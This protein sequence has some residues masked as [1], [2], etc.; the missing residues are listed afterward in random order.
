MDRRLIALAAATSLAPAQSLLVLPQS[1]AQLDG[2]TATSVPFGRS[3]PVRVQCLYD[4]M[5][6]A[7]P[8]NVTA[9]A[10][11][12]DGGQS[13]PGK[14]VDCELRL[15]TSPRGLVTMG[16]D[17]AGN[18]GAD[19]V[20]VLPRQVLALPASTTTAT[21]SPFLPPI[22]LAVPFHYDPAAGPLLLEITVFGQPP[23]SY[24]LDATFVC[25][26]PEV[27]VGPPACAPAQGQPL[28]VESATQQVLWGRPWLARALDAPAGAPVVLGLGDTDVMTSTGVP[29]PIPLDV[30]GATGCFLSINATSLSFQVAQQDGTA[31]FAFTVPNQPTLL[32]YWAFFQAGVFAPAANPAGL[33]TSQAKR[34]QVCGFEPVARLWAGS[35][36][37]VVG[38]LETGTAPVIQITLQ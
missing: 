3:G 36:T 28:R 6:F 16:A 2:T 7:A 37:A 10:F 33:A 34:V 17:F 1:H 12:L 11:R 19:E 15:S 22:A 18:R 4:P 8:G 24:V 14:Q 13:A 27:L 25:N 21:P 30:I 20:V 23:G 9:I 29:L 32:G 31:T 26:S 5:L 35:T 38:N